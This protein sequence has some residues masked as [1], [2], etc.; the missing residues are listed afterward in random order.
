MINN[1]PENHSGERTSLCTKC[2]CNQNSINRLVNNKT[3]ADWL[4]IYS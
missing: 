4:E 2:L 1:S 3:I